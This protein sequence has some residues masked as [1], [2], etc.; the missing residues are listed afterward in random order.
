MLNG[1]VGLRPEGKDEEGEDEVERVSLRQYYKRLT[2]VR[3]TIVVCGD[4]GRAAWG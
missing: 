2:C 3:R 1:G 4:V